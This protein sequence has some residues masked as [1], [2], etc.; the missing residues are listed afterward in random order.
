VRLHGGGSKEVVSCIARSPTSSTV[1][2][3][4][5]LNAKQHEQ[6]YADTNSQSGRNAMLANFLR[7]NQSG[8]VLLLGNLSS[9]KIQQL[10]A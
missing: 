1:L 9:F 2:P 8:A 10:L 7:R 4:L 3:R 5:G 6:N